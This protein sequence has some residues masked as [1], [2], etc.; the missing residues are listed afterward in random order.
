MESWIFDYRLLLIFSLAVALIAY[1]FTRLSSKGT[2]FFDHRS[3]VDQD[4]ALLKKLLEEFGLEI[5]S[6]LSESKSAGVK[7]I[8]TP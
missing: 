7:S 1:F 8:E 6:E 5:P 3:K 4:K 2:Y